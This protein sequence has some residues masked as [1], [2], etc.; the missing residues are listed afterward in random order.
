[1]PFAN[2]RYLAPSLPLS[3]SLSLSLIVY[4]KFSYVIRN[5]PLK[6]QVKPQMQFVWTLTQ[7]LAA[8][9]LGHSLCWNCFYSKCNFPYCLHLHKQQKQ[10]LKNVS[11][12]HNLICS[13]RPTRNF[14]LLHT[15]L[16]C[17]HSSF[18]CAKS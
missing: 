1:M 12:K 13:A 17:D 5:F 2:L 15:I 18:V 11:I 14:E 9:R 6:R 10:Q 4:I 16:H 7:S 8:A 3:C